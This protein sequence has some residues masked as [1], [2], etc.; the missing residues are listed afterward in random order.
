MSRTEFMHPHPPGWPFRFHL[1]RISI[2]QPRTCAARMASSHFNHGLRRKG[3]EL[4][5]APT[6]AAMLK[7]A[8][9]V[10]QDE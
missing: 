8:V 2:F 10:S 1:G 9:V 7:E 3:G 6:N 5:Q 4:A